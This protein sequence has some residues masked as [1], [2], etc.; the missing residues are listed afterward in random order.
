MHFSPCFRFSPYFRKIFRLCGKFSKFLPF[1]EKFLDFHPPKFLMAL[2]QSSTTTFE[3][4]PISLFQYIIPLFREKLLFL[5]YFDKFS[6][7]FRKIH[8]LNFTCF[9]CISFPPY[10]DHD[11]FMHHPMHVLDAP[12]YYFLQT[13]MC[14]QSFALVTMSKVVFIIIILSND[15]YFCI[16]QKSF[17]CVFKFNVILKAFIIYQQFQYY[18]NTSVYMTVFGKVYIYHTLHVHS[19]R[20]IVY[21]LFIY[22]PGLILLLLF[23]DMLQLIN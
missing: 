20:T 6:S 19:S 18:C 14:H 8:L 22:R 13:L 17:T 11:A 15:Q 21:L 4:P 10:F 2:F 3:F 5:P 1:P 7:C 12:E 23:C 16:F 9:V